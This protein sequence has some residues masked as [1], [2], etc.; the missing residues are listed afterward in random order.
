MVKKLALDED[1]FF[2]EASVFGLISELPDYRLC[3]MI[4]NALKLKLCRTEFDREMKVKKE[5]FLYS[6]FEYFDQERQ[7]TWFLTT[8]RKGRIKAAEA[9]LAKDINP[10]LDSDMSSIPLVP[11]LKMLDYFLWYEG[12]STASVDAFINESLK[13]LPYVRTFQKVNIDSS[14]HIKNLLLEY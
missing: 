8:N 6:E 10:M 7:I 14:K 4:N 2:K 13:T 3:F 5:T 11:D 9:P 12:E 1:F